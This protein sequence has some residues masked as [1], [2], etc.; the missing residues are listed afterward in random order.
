M[1]WASSTLAFTGTSAEE[2]RAA[3]DWGLELMDDEPRLQLMDK[4]DMGFAQFVCSFT[5]LGALNG[6]FSTGVTGEQVKRGVKLH[7]NGSL[8]V[9]AYWST[10]CSVEDSESFAK[11]HDSHLA[12][13]NY[14]MTSVCYLCPEDL[15]EHEET[16]LGPGC[17]AGIAWE[18]RYDFQR[19]HQRLMLGGMDV[20]VDACMVP[21][22]LMLRF[23]NIRESSVP[24]DRWADAST[25]AAD[26]GSPFTESAAASW[27]APVGSG[28]LQTVL[29][30]RNLTW[31]NVDGTVEK[32]PQMRNQWTQ[33]EGGVTLACKL[34][35]QSVGV[36]IKGSMVVHLPHQAQAAEAR[37]WLK[38]VDWHYFN[39]EVQW[40]TFSIGSS[41][42][43]LTC[44]AAAT[45]GDLQLAARHAK[46]ALGYTRNPKRALDAAL[47]LGSLLGQPNSGL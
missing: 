1:L 7:I 21:M 30:S 41:S 13:W 27:I 36:C 2:R 28:R 37:Q 6:R 3:D 31:E 20:F 9:L 14:A 22:I 42:H 38:P 29:R 40:E 19:C 44:E 25:Q 16:M 46:A 35:S 5:H 8:K 4:R 12:H 11:W 26:V 10:K 33:E 39:V 32:V 15:A 47:K 24:L 43:A 23:G 18:S 17:T 34:H 45:L